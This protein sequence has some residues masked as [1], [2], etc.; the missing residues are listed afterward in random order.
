MRMPG[1]KGR[2]VLRIDPAKAQLRVRDVRAGSEA[3]TAA[4]VRRSGGHLAVINAGFFDL[5]GSPMGLLISD[6][7]QLQKLR[8]VDWGVLYLDSSGAHIV[9]TRDFRHRPGMLQAMQSGPRLVVDGEVVKLKPQS[10]RRSAVGIDGSGRVVLMAT[11]QSLGAAELARTL[12]DLGCLQALNLDGGP[13]AQLSL[14][15]SEGS[16]VEVVGGVPVPV[17][18]TVDADPLGVPVAKERPASDSAGKGCQA[19]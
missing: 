13:S 11:E 3:R 7:R 10:S 12:R 2:H 14:A 6:G 18:L 17:A 8:P 4:Q 1:P 19:W 9:H 16:D 5:D 15:L